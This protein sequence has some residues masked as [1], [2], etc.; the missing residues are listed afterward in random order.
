[1]R[2]PEPALNTRVPLRFAG[3]QWQPL[4]CLLILLWDCNDNGDK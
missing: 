1:M 3:S 4:G 2:S